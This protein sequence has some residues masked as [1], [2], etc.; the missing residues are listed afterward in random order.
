[1]K[2]QNLAQTRS[3]R[4][5]AHEPPKETP[6]RHVFVFCSMREPFPVD[7]VQQI[8]VI[9]S[10][11]ANVTIDGA[12]LPTEI[13]AVV[14]VDLGQSAGDELAPKV[15]EVKPA[16]GVGGGRVDV[17]RDAEDLALALVVAF[18]EPA[19]EVGGAVIFE[20]WVV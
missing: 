16:F 11:Q 5:E 6:I 8:V 13:A 9:C 20:A 14:G 4:L 19:A 15:A 2:A 3:R 18:F 10:R 17:E 7:L 1:M 12:V